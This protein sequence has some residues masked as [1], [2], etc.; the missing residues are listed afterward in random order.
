MRCCPADSLRA[1]PAC[2]DA[3]VSGSKPS[4]SRLASAH[5]CSEVSRVMT[6]S[7]M[8]NRTVRPCSAAS[9][10]IQAIFSATCAGGSPQVRY[11]STCRAAISPAIG[12]EPPK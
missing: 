10:L 7:R 5:A 11:T 12:E 4:S 2:T 8:P 9:F 1:S 3:T 6:C